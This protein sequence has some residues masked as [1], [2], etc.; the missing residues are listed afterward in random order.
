MSK[1]ILTF[2]P[3]AMRVTDVKLASQILRDLVNKR[4]MLEVQTEG[5][6]T[7]V[8]ESLLNSFDC[9]TQNVEVG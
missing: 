9:L 4:Q 2:N 5:N 1:L 3:D 6:F 7:M 8:A